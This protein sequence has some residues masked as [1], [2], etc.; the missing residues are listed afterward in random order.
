LNVIHYASKTLNAAQKNYATTEK[1]FIAIVFACDKF[2][3]Y[4]VDL[5]VT[6]HTDHAAIRYIMEKKDA[7]PRLIRWVWLLQEFDLH[8]VDRKGAENLVANNLSRL[9]NIS[10]DLILVN[11]SFPN[12]QLASIKVTL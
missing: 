2:R 10:Y 7:K 12:D 11:D 3:P 5:E 8:I 9:E 6:I 4:I 1:E